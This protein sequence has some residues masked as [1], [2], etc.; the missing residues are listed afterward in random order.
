MPQNFIMCNL[1]AGVIMGETMCAYLVKMN[2]R[3]T[4]KCIIFERE[5]LE[6]KIGYP[7]GIF[8]YTSACLLVFV[9]VV[10]MFIIFKQ[11]VNSSRPRYNRSLVLCCAVSKIKYRYF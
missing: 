2:P 4:T 5:E 9:S 11:E 7:Y 10:L 8:F 1:I 3:I 6:S